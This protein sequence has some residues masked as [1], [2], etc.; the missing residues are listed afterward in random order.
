MANEICCLDGWEAVE[1]VDVVDAIT[2]VIVDDEIA[3][4]ERGEVLEEV[5]ALTGFHTIVLQSGFDDEFGGT[6]MRPL[7]RD[8]Q[9]RVV[10]APAAWT[11]KN[12]RLACIEESPIDSFY[13][14]GDTWI[15]GC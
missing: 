8:A 15:V 4:T 13:L 5:G 9:P 10:A 7:H 2:N 11:Y 3:H 6:D 12:V 14:I 1:V